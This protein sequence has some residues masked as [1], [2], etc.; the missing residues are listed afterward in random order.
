M[1]GN[2]EMIKTMNR[3]DH[4]ISYFKLY[5]VDTVNALQK[6]SCSSSFAMKKTTKNIERLKE[7]DIRC[8]HNTPSQ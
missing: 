1:T 4:N 7:N 8:Q 2:T 6:K 5:E 3:L